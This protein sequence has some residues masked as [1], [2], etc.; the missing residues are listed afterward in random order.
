M[1]VISSRSPEH[2]LLRD[3]E[4]VELVR[5]R[6]GTTV[7]VRQKSRT[8]ISHGLAQRLIL[9]LVVSDVPRGVVDGRLRW[10]HK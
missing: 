6:P 5:L 2:G 9:H 10:G 7:H 3:R 8:S 4:L 1:K